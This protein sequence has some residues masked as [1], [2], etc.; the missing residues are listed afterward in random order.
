MPLL[1][2]SRGIA[3]VSSFLAET[4]A[5]NSSSKN[6]STGARFEVFDW[7]LEAFIC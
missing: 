7:K 6:F 4:K 1:G 5:M 3:L 2:F